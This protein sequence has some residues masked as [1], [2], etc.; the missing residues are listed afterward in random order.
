[1]EALPTYPKFMQ[2]VF[3][4][5]VNFDRLDVTQRL[6]G[7]DTLSIIAS[8]VEGKLQLAKLTGVKAVAFVE[9]Y[10][11]V[12]GDYTNAMEL[13]MKAFGKAIRS[14]PIELRA[15]HLDAL[16]ALVALPVRFSSC[17][18]DAGN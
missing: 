6:L 10:Q 4:L 9:R 16:S 17:F 2:S 12:I 11:G 3:D 7:F 1:M 18:C 13:S 15:R 8:T 14:G 5:V